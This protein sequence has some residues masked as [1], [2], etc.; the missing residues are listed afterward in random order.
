[1]LFFFF[2]KHIITPTNF[3]WKSCQGSCIVSYAVSYKIH[4]N[5]I[6]V[7]IISFKKKK[8]KKAEVLKHYL[9]ARAEQNGYIFVL[10]SLLINPHPD[11]ATSFP[12][13][14]RF[15]LLSKNGV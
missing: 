7:I 12:V 15:Y 8:N 6:N 5:L 13:Q 1:M 4:K 10:Y 14:E 3:L 11:N 2:N 9:S